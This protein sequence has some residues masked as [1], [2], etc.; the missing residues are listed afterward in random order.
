MSVGIEL[1]ETCD[2]TFV[3]GN[4]IAN[5]FIGI[6]INSNNNTIEKNNFFKNVFSTFF[7]TINNS[8]YQ[9]YWNRPRFLPKLI[10]GMTSKWKIHICFDKN[11]TKRPWNLY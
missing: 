8:W 3:S 10:F 9:N 2:N 11:P 7:S 5:N 4:T 1:Y 6:N